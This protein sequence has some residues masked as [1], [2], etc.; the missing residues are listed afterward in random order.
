MAP[1]ATQ[2]P[3]FA[4]EPIA[5]EPA[6]PSAEDVA[7]ATRIPPG[8]RLGTSSWSFP[9]W[10]GSVWQCSVR[11]ALLARHGLA[12]YARHPLLRAVGIDRSY[13][14]PPERSL[15]ARYAAE[16]PDG[17]RFLVKAHEHVTCAQLRAPSGRSEP[18]PR[19]LDAAYA[20][21]AVVAPAVAGL[22]P[23]LGALVFQFPPQ[24]PA[25]AGGPEGFAERLHGF[26]TR[27]PRGPAY[28]VEI[29]NQ[30]W[31]TPAYVQALRDA[32]AVH[33]LALHPRMPD[34]EVQEAALAPDAPLLVARWMLRRGMRYEQARERYAPFDRL[35]EPDPR[36]RERLAGLLAR[37]AAR[38]S[39]AL[40]TVNNKAEGSAPLSVFA[41]ARRTAALLEAGR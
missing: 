17:F 40:V 12:A 33:C 7:A 19:F 28:A 22:G 6:P 3:L 15:L 37:T 18:N 13:Y 14:A 30:A 9:G 38:G 29:R 23:K 35:A 36:N 21:D 11:P 4:R 10:T 34:L 41:L 5:V 32:G 39:A 25:L 8:V 20:T 16:V 26:L 31:F 24:D 1:V 27:L 2:I